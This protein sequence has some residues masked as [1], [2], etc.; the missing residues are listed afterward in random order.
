MR[1]AY[2]AR[3]IAI[4]MSVTLLPL[5][6][7]AQ[8][9]DAVSES[10]PE[11]VCLSA[12]LAT[13]PTVAPMSLYSADS[14][15]STSSAIGDLLS[16]ASGSSAMN[17]DQAAVQRSAMDNISDGSVQTTDPWS[18]DASDTLATVDNAP[19]QFALINLNV[20][21]GASIFAS[22]SAGYHLL[23]LGSPFP[24]P[25]LASFA[26]GTVGFIAIRRLRRQELSE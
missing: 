13:S 22:N 11:Q 4:M 1:L 6:G 19:D 7:Y 15:N 14:P 5:L 16:G 10:S 26:L 12:N 21:V 24:K 23:G 20:G 25:A 9:T 2:R 17:S 8:S 18:G 3:S